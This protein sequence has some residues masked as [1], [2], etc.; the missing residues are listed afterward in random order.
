MDTR[1]MERPGGDLFAG[2]PGDLCQMPSH[3]EIG[4]L[5]AVTVAANLA[6]VNRRLVDHRRAHRGA[7]PAGRRSH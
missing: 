6:L 3:E 2:P 4:S 7:A 5:I 1:H